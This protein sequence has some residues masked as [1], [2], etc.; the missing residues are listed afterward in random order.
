MELHE[1]TPDYT[2][3]PRFAIHPTDSTAFTGAK[4]TE[5]DLAEEAA[6]RGFQRAVLEYY[7]KYGR[8][9]PWRET[10]DPYKILVSEIML[11]QTQTSR[12]REKYLEFTRAV[13]SFEALS[14]TPLQ[15]VLT[16][17]QGLGYNRRAKSLKQIGETVVSHYGGKL[18]R[19]PETLETL[20]GIG[21]A[22]ARSIAAFAFNEPVV[23]IETNIRFVFIYT[24]FSS[25]DTVH[26]REILPLVEQSLYR[27]NISLWYNALMDYGSFLK[28]RE[29]EIAMK[30][31]HYTKQ[32]PF[33]NS[34]RQIRGA[35]LRTLTSRGTISIPELI[36]ELPYPDERIRKA[37]FQLE[38]ERFLAIQDG[39]VVL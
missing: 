8:T 6:I 20:P 2:R 7:E 4:N 17:W 25:H 23:F 13:P 11:Q 39:V 10:G 19:S 15:N 36:E 35:I 30:S 26:D 31:A 24:F 37:L 9:F 14:E 34:N 21:P 27:E 38:T 22:T 3:F 16:L 18:P 12:V 5:N 1:Q 28:N 32:A 33:K 29:P